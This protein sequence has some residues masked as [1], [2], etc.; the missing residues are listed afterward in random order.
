MGACRSERVQASGARSGDGVPD[1]RSRRVTDVRERENGVDRR[2]LD[3]TRRTIGVPDRPSPRVCSV[4]GAVPGGAG[5]HG[6]NV[7]L[8]V[9][10]AAGGQARGQRDAGLDDVR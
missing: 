2:D 5:R 3:A 4:P 6:G 10:G 1:A 7:C 8:L 9:E